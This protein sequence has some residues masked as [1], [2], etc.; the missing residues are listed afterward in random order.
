MS[1]LSAGTPP[2]LLQG[3]LLDGLDAHVARHLD[4]LSAHFMVAPGGATDGGGLA[5]AVAGVGV[6]VGAV[7]P[8]GLYDDDERLTEGVRGLLDGVQVVDQFGERARLAPQLPAGEVQEGHA[9]LIH[10]GVDGDDVA[11]ALFF[12]RFHRYLFTFKKDPSN[13]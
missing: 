5:M 6:P 4:N 11:R 12:F 9:R 1:D 2:A 7:E 8:S 3:T 10:V 13:G